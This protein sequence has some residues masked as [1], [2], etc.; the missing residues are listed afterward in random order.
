MGVSRGTDLADHSSSPPPV[1]P[2]LVQYLT[3]AIGRLEETFEDADD[4]RVFLENVLTETSGQEVGLLCDRSC[5]H[6]LERLLPVLDTSQLVKFSSCLSCCEL[7]WLMCDISASRVLESL[8][9]EFGR[10]IYGNSPEEDTEKV[11]GEV[12]RDVSALLEFPCSVADTVLTQCDRAMTDQCAS[13]VLRA[14]LQ[15]LSGQVVSDGSKSRDGVLQ[16]SPAAPPSQLQE[17]LVT[18]IGAITASSSV[19]ECVAST[20]VST[21]LQ[22]ALRS[23]HSVGLTQLTAALCKRVSGALAPLGA[24]LFEEPASQRVLEVCV[25]CAVEESTRQRLFDLHFRGRILR[26]LTSC[27]CRVSV[28]RLVEACGCG[29]M[30]GDIVSEVMGGGKGESSWWFESRVP[31]ALCRACVRLSAQQPEFLQLLSLCHQLPQSAPH[32]VLVAAALYQVPGEQVAALLGGAGAVPVGG[33]LLLQS[34]LKFSRSDPFI[35]GL[36]QL[37]VP[38]LSS[39]CTSPAGSHLIDTLLKLP[40]LGEKRRTTLLRALYQQ[41]SQ[42]ACSRHGSRVLET[43]WHASSLALRAFMA[44]TLVG[45]RQRVRSDF[46][47]RHVHRVM[48]LDLF[49]AKKHDW[50]AYM[51][52]DVNKRKMFADIVSPDSDSKRVCV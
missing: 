20:V 17:K 45:E 31:L 21:V 13:P 6:V 52:R 47:G 37:P 11:Q 43:A 51:K 7:E 26:L 29:R 36:L 22:M 4:R 23:T 2:D 50:L 32:Q 48:A 14:C 44:E 9:R 1:D 3:T 15:C 35:D 19:S 41:L 16:G 24:A 49:A 33:S 28:Q 40:R 18:L 38:V 46:F 39:C 34:L 25:E 27:S 42:L 5:S 12:S 10:R 8:L 30:L